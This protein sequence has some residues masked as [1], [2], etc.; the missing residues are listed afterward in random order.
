MS[1]HAMPCLPQ[2]RHHGQCPR[3]TKLGHQWTNKELL[4][5]ASPSDTDFVVYS[6][7]VASLP[8]KWYGADG[9]PNDETLASRE[10][11]P[12]MG[13]LDLMLRHREKRRHRLL[14]I[15]STFRGKR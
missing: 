10:V 5:V 13:L 15:N 1:A 12:L 3:G 7:L 14:S 4:R 9:G 11:T 2:A 8:K 6:L